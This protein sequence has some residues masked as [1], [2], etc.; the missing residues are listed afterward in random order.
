MDRVALELPVS[1]KL[2][3]SQKM[4]GNRILGENYYVGKD[5]Q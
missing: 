5:V 4:M 2:K 3:K 1:V